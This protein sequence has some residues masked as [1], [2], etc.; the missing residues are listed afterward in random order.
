MTDLADRLVIKDGNVFAVIRRDGAWS[1][2]DGVWMDD[3]RHVSR[4]E[5]RIDGSPP[6]PLHAD[7]DGGSR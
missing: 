5:L 6:R 1:G 7:D 3:C 2:V 4:H